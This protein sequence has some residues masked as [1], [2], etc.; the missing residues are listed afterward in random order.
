[1]TGGY[2]PA[3]RSCL[4]CLGLSGKEGG[5]IISEDDDDDE[6]DDE[7]DDDDDG[8]DVCRDEGKE[9]AER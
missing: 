2:F 6:D 3:E 5:T 8:D 7:D 4:Y 9:S 1:M